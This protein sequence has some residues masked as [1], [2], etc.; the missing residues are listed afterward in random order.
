MI[1]EPRLSNKA[2]AELCHRLAVEMEAGVDIRRT[3]TRE[4]ESARGRLRPYF[5]H[6]REGLARGDTFAESLA[7][8]AVV[9]PPLFLEMTHVGEET[10]TLAKVLRRLERHYDRLVKT[11]RTFFVA[12]AWPMLELFAA[13]G[14]IGILIAV[15]GWVGNRSGGQNADMLGFGL[16]GTSGLAIYITF[17]LAIAVGVAAMRRGVLWTRPL[18]R[19]LLRLPVVGGCLQKVALA[20]MA[21]VLHLTMNVAMD[22]RRAAGLSLRAT[23]NDYYARHADGVSKSIQSGMPLAQALARTGAFPAN[24]IETLAVGEE[25]GQIVESMERL[26]DRYEDESAAA[27]RVLAVIA[28]ALVFALVA[29]IIIWL[30]F[31]L[32]NAYMAPVREALEM[33]KPK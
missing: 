13:I 7:R 12:I 3:W 25:S 5:D 17:W 19:A 14:I 18:Q 21:W 23:G 10:G 4:A 30:I 16:V 33:I 20:Q 28:G 9:F 32:F 6:V 8:S 2:L 15:M 27:I 22:V 1:V 24:F 29:A 31:R 26:A 11:R